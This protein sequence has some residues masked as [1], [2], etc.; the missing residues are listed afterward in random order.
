[1]LFAFKIHFYQT[2]TNLKI[3]LAYKK[4]TKVVLTILSTK[5][6]FFMTKNLVVHEVINII[7]NFVIFFYIKNKRMFC[8]KRLKITKI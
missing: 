4:I 7:N 8:T 1:M 6:S 5:N 2:C 3:F